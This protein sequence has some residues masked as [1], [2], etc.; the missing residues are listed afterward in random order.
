VAAVP[1]IDELDVWGTSVVSSLQKQ[2]Q[3][4]VLAESCTCGLVASTLAAIPGISNS[5]CGSAVTYRD[6][7]KARW[8][9]VSEKDLADPSITAVSR[10]VAAQMCQGVLDSTPEATLAASITGH[11]GPES[12]LGFDGLIYIAT[13]ARGQ[14][15]PM[16]LSFVL[17]TQSTEGRTVRET[18]RRTA[19][20]HMLQ[21]ILQCLTDSP[22]QAVV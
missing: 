3:R 1:E 14:P 12:P 7:T 19:T 13:C 20:V 21:A 10:Q 9:K 5:F 22:L 2:R 8:L 18:R 6:D 15:E 4:L 17:P 11:L 16:I